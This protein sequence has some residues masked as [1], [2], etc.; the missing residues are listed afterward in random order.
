MK[1]IEILVALVL[2]PLA[3]VMKKG[4]GKQALIA[5]MLQLLGHPPGVIYALYVIT[6][7][8]RQPSHS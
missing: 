7:T 1:V 2:P 3:V 6:S 4:L 8:E 5:L